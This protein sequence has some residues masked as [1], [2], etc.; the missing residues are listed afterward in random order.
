M[1]T[2]EEELEEIWDNISSELSAIFQGRGEIPQE[3]TP[4][5]AASEIDVDLQRYGLWGLYWFQRNLLF[6]QSRKLQF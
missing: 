5:D 4:F 6:F 1:E 3:V 2:T